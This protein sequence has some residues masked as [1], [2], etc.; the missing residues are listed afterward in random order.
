MSDDAFTAPKGATTLA[1]DELPALMRGLAIAAIVLGILGLGQAAIGVVTS[2]NME[3]VAELAASQ[4]PSNVRDEYD[5]LMAAQV[6]YQPLGWVTFL[7]SFVVSGL[8]VAGGAIALARKALALLAWAALGAATVDVIN[9]LVQILVRVATNAE[10]E[11]YNEAVSQIAGGSAGAV[12][13]LAGMIIGLV[14]LGAF[15][16]FWGYAYIR[17]RA[18]MSGPG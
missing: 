4:L 12:G 6:A 3:A 8:M 1:G 18:A 17:I 11:A 5:T 13:G 15:A 7:L 14:F 2:L 16:A 9:I 10:W